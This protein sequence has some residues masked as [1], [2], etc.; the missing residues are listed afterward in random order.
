MAI[1]SE[2]IPALRDVSRYQR[3]AFQSAELDFDTKGVND[4][5]SEV[6]RRS[7]K[8]ILAALRNLDPGAGILAE[9]EGDDRRPDGMDRW[10][11]I[12]PLDGTGNFRARI[13]IWAIGVGL[14][15]NGIPV[16]G[17]VVDS[18]SGRVWS[19]WDAT[20]PERPASRLIDAQMWALDSAFENRSYPEVM[21]AKR[22]QIGATVLA[23]L[24]LTQPGFEGRASLDFALMGNSSLWDI[25]GPAAFLR[26]IGGTLLVDT[27]QR[28][29]DLTREPLDRLAPGGLTLLRKRKLRYVASASP[30]LAR[31][32]AGAGYLHAKW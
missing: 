7:Q 23:L 4:F 10:Y 32:V 6:D 20:P 29:H 27:G 22:R 26:Q 15:E 18:Y 5:V 14:F 28:L 17:V 8:T 30:E 1:L 11:V 13:P 25:A 31:S 9:E 24:L 16:E 12:D 21:T 2:L 19:S 3:E